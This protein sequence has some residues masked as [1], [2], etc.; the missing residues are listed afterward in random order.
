MDPNH[1]LPE[2]SG[3]LT[4]QLEGAACSDSHPNRTEAERHKPE[5]EQRQSET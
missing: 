5:T 1:R 4:P 2:C 3:S